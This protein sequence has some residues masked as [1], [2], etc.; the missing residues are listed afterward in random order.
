MTD[1]VAPDAAGDQFTIEDV[2]GSHRFELRD[3]G[4][5]MGFADYHDEGDSRVFTHTVVDSAYGGQ[6]LGSRLVR[7]VLDDAVARGKR[8]VP[9]CSFT[10]AYLRRHH[11]YDEHVDWPDAG[12]G[13]G[14]DAVL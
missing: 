13:S 3:R 10:A 8:I 11:D 9:V 12:P 14:G 7:F 4:T 2:P 6:G 1:N 5:R